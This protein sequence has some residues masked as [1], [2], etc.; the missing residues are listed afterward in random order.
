MESKICNFCKTAYPITEFTF[1]KRRGRHGTRCRLCRNTKAKDWRARNAERE[2]E[3]YK[4]DVDRTR[5]RH[6]ERKYGITKER[7]QELLAKQDGKCAICGDAP[8]RR[9]RH[10][11]HVDH[12][13]K[14]GRVRGLLC[15]G[16][17]HML[18][19]VRDDKNVLIRAVAY[20]EEDRSP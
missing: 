16:C 15:R 11:L 19:V 2:K 20:L 7:Y 5:W 17:N 13:H 6:I 10:Q 14:T 1:D 18:G 3:R 12:C 8:G 4:K 9:Y